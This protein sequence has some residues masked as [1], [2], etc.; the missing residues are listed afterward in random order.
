MVEG[1]V[2]EVLE[3]RGT[4]FPPEYQ[5]SRVFVPLIWGLAPRWRD[6]LERGWRRLHGN[7]DLLRALFA[8]ADM[9]GIVEPRDL[10]PTTRQPMVLGYI[11]PAA[12]ER[13][14]ASTGLGLELDAEL[15]RLAGLSVRERCA[16]R[17]FG[18]APGRTGTRSLPRT[19]QRRGPPGNATR[20][21]STTRARRHSGSRSRAAAFPPHGRLGK[22][23][24]QHPAVTAPNAC[25]HAR[26]GSGGREDV[27]RP[28]VLPTRRGVPALSHF[29]APPP[30]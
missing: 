20:G 15:G 10:G 12:Q 16:R 26:A 5:W 6:T 23:G 13:F 19:G 22:V 3:L 7:M 9:M 27:G 25:S 14:L 4:G 21:R 29:G 28:P 24:F 18:P 8:A 2:R 11:Q 1:L 30:C 17:A